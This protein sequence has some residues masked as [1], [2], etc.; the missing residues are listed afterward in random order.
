MLDTVIIDIYVHLA[1][2][3][4]DRS[5]EELGVGHLLARWMAH[6]LFESTWV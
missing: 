5:F 6:S 2:R 1:V 3:A 4:S